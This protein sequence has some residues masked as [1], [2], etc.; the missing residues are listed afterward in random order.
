MRLSSLL[1]STCIILFSYFASAAA[2]SSELDNQ[3]CER[4]LGLTLKSREPL[5]FDRGAGL[6][7]RGF[8][9]A[10]PS[11]TLDTNAELSAKGIFFWGHSF[12]VMKSLEEAEAHDKKFEGSRRSCT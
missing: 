4:M 3:L 12:A 10:A 5:D 1:M 6:S 2:V 11:L 8:L 7:M 9:G